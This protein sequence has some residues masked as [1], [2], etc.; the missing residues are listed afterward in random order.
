GRGPSAERGG[1]CL[2]ACARGWS[3]GFRRA[4]V[5]GGRVM[6]GAID[7]RPRGH[8]R[9][10]WLVA[11]ICAA[12]AAAAMGVRPAAAQFSENNPPWV[13][14]PRVPNVPTASSS[15]ETGQN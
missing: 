4:F 11:L 10:G 2:V 14:V 1:G 8:I 5:P 13:G 3:H 7:A 15:F 6:A 12:T 9:R